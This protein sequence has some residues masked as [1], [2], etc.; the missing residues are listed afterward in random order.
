MLI[1]IMGG[2]K[3]N[4]IWTGKKMPDLEIT[5]KQ[6]ISLQDYLSKMTI[7][8]SLNNLFLLLSVNLAK[9]MLCKTNIL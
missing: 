4:V 3:A 6:I 8:N 1:K 2:I 5:Q 7:Y 9:C